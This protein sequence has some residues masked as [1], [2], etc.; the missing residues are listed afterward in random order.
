[1][2]LKHPG[3]VLDLS[4]KYTA[5][6]EATKA[7]IPTLSFKLGSDYLLLNN[8]SPNIDLQYFY[9]SFVMAVYYSHTINLL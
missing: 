4:P 2:L 6:S 1:M 7:N 9:L 5:G 3:A 8:T